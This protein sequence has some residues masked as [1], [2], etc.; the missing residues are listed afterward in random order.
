MKC[1]YR[2]DVSERSC[3]Y[4]AR[5][6]DVCTVYVCPWF[7][8]DIKCTYGVNVRYVTW[9][10]LKDSWPNDHAKERSKGGMLR[11]RVEAQIYQGSVR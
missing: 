3:K 7:V 5:T 9:S 4:D 10:F 1:M 2:D 6:I 11:R 8:V